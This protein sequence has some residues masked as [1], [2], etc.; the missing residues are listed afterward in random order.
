MDERGAQRF[1]HTRLDDADPLTMI[2][3]DGQNDD[4]ESPGS[5]DPFLAAEEAAGLIESGGA[6]AGM[7]RG[8][9]PRKSKARE[10]SNPKPN[11]KIKK[12]HR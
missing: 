2:R 10:K 6:H 1:G 5:A 9:K 3:G 8:E 4:D 11:T 7:G 12:T